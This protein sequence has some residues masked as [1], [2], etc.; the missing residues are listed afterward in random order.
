MV[1]NYYGRVFPIF[2]ISSTFGPLLPT[3]GADQR[4]PCVVRGSLR[5]TVL[6]AGPLLL[7]KIVVP[8][9][10]ATQGRPGLTAG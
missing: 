3:A 7:I 8:H 6:L 5:E 9:T 10:H 4:E 1:L 2:S